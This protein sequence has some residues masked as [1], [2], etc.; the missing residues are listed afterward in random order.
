MVRYW[1][2]LFPVAEVIVEPVGIVRYDPPDL[3]SSSQMV[4][5][6]FPSVR[7]R[8]N[9]LMV[10]RWLYSDPEIFQ[11][12]RCHLKTEALTVNPPVGKVLPASHESMVVSPV[13]A[14]IEVTIP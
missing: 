9:V 8:D 10:F 1:K 13:E 14:L 5:P 2:Y 7:R 12:S 3:K 6:S 4:R 11:Y